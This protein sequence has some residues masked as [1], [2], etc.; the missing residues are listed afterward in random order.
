[1]I[2]LST[3]SLLS[4]TGL[5]E[6]LTTLPSS[7]PYIFDLGSSRG[8]FVNGQKIEKHTYIELKTD[9]VLRFGKA[10]DLTVTY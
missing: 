9:D 1:M 7:R 5:H 4:F 8:T 6:V 10:D 3:L 2:P